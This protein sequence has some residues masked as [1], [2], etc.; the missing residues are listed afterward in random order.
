M[1]I[2]AVIVAGFIS[3]ILLGLL[4]CAVY[5]SV[6]EPASPDEQQWQQDESLRGHTGIRT[7]LASRGGRVLPPQREGSFT[8]LPHA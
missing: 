6:M 5:I 4:G 3:V 2:V 8:R 1:F 7:N